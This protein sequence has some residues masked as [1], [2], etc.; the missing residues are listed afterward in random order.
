MDEVIN[1]RTN[2][3]LGN[4]KFHIELR[5]QNH[6]VMWDTKTLMPFRNLAPLLQMNPKWFP[7]L[8]PS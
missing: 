4:S 1:P 8:Y 2:R 6:N 5:T 7:N 3:Q